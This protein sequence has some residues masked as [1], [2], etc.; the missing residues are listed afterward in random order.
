MIIVQDKTVCP[1]NGISCYY[2]SFGLFV[3]LFLGP[4]LSNI[5][6]VDCNGEV[7]NFGVTPKN[8]SGTFSYSSDADDDKKIKDDFFSGHDDVKVTEKDQLTA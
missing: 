5:Q 7:Y 1:I 6:L 2:C 8:D 3:L 4:K